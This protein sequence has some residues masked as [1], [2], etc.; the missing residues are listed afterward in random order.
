MRVLMGLRERL[1]TM[2]RRLLTAIYTK[3]TKARPTHHFSLFHRKGK[4]EGYDV[5]F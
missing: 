5:Y 1:R 3:W 2:D 4:N